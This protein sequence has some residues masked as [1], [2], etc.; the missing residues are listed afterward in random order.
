M[1]HGDRYLVPLVRIKN[2][3]GIN[4]NL[5]KLRIFDIKEVKFYKR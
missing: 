1:R 5:I 4:P 3:A 2:K